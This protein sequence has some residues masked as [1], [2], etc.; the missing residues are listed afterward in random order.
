MIKDM[1]Q[2]GEPVE[3][4]GI[5]VTPLFPRRDPVASFITLDEALPQGLR[6]T[7][8]DE[9]GSVPELVVRNPLTE[10]VLLYDGEELVGAKQNRIVERSVLVA[11]GAT[12]KIPVKCVEQ[13]RWSRRTAH[14]EPVPRAAYPELRR[15]TLDG[16][17]AVWDEV[18]AK[19]H[20]LRAASPTGAVEAVYERRSSTIEEY[21][22]AL[23]RQDGQCGA[24]VGI[25]GR[26]TCLDYVSRSDVF[27]GLHGKLLR[28]YALSAL[29]S[30]VNKPSR[31]RQSDVSSA[32]SSS[33]PAPS[34][35]GP[36]SAKSERWTAM[37][38]A[39]SSSP[40]ARRSRCRRF[41][42]ARSEFLHRA[43][44]R[45]GSMPCGRGRTCV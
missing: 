20:R 27:A 21:L 18:A 43:A 9:A 31:R 3:H 5:V 38:S 28:G 22:D 14:F 45:S 1:V 12:L 30:P 34:T 24:L 29:E 35:Q 19:S 40:T 16:Q 15:A 10:R 39:R 33:C 7:E 26:L 36:A 37:Q 44:R 6:I 42:V 25:A 23:P 4:R 8:V 17:A 13:G 32:S 11:A 2:V 41:L